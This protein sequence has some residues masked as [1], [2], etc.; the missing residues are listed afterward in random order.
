MYAAVRCRLTALMADSSADWNLQEEL[1]P[2]EDILE[3]TQYRS[4]KFM[5][6]QFYR[7]K[8]NWKVYVDNYLDG[9]YHVDVLHKSLS[10]Q[11][12]Q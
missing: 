1:K 9:G 11:V 10:A 7:V 5:G 8:S 6:S 12:H 2:L 4:L 3:S